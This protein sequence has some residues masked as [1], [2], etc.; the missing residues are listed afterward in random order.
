MWGM[1]PS[2]RRIVAEKPVPDAAALAVAE[3]LVVLAD[4]SATPPAVASDT[5]VIA[6]AATIRARRLERPAAAAPRLIVFLSLKSTRPGV[7]EATDA[8]RARELCQSRGFARATSRDAAAAD[9]AEPFT[10]V[11]A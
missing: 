6:A 8:I 10:S 4:E 9:D 7:D 5:L 2:V 3:P 1:P 11:V